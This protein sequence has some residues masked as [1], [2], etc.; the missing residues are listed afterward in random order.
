MQSVFVV[1]LLLSSIATASNLPTEEPMGGETFGHSV[2]NIGDGLYVFRWWVYR[3]IFIV[4]DD[5]VIVTD[6]INPKAANL[7]LGEIRKITDK[8]VSMLSIATII[9]TIFLVARCSRT[10]ERLSSLT[11]MC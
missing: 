6:P 7:L 4:T 1:G 10:R 2:K 5:G 9:M 8:P 3:N 11:K